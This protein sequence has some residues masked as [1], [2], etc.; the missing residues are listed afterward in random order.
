M[1]HEPQ[2]EELHKEMLILLKDF[3]DLCI[4]NDIKYSLHGGTLLGAIR[5]K[6]FIPWDD[7]MDVTMTRNE[8]EKFKLI[9]KQSEILS[10]SYEYGLSRIF[11]QLDNGIFVWLDIFIYDYIS[12]NATIKRIKILALALLRAWLKTPEDMK[13]T[14]VHGVYKGWKYFAIYFIHL[15]GVPFTSAFK[16]KIADKIYISFPG[17]KQLIHRSN[18]QYVALGITLPVSSMENYIMT[19]FED[20]QL[21]IT[22]DY[23]LV[24]TTSYGSD[25]MIPKKIDNDIASHSEFRNIRKK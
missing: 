15:L 24:L 21:M 14:K 6:G 3:N 1:P 12:G 5:E 2:Y 13:V 25:Y 10:F 7:D 23:N 20:T 22:S 8:F 17:N 4:K 16:N 11:K 9:I 19:E 18:D